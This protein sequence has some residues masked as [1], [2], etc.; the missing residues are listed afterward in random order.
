MKRRILPSIGL[1]AWLAAS[2]QPTRLAVEIPR[3]EQPHLDA[4]INAEPHA[5][6]PAGEFWTQPLQ[7]GRAS[8]ARVEMLESVRA[9]V[10]QGAPIRVT[11]FDDE[12]VAGQQPREKAMADNILAARRA[13]ET[14]IVLVGNLHARTVPGA[15]WDPKVVWMSVFLRDSE[16][17][18][19]TLDTRYTAGEAWICSGPKPEDCGVKPVKGK[20][21]GEAWQVERYAQGDSNG[22]GGV[23][24]TGKAVVSRPAKESE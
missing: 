24:Q 18:L 13:G 9:L 17:Q 16:P 20:G 6:L 1:L 19:L 21:A 8:R 11:A 14:T 23:F 4:F 12:S 7:D 3:Q 2:G 5:S 15:P 22:Y 10:K